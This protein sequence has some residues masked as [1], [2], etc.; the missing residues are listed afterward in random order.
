MNLEIQKIPVPK[1]YIH[2]DPPS[3]ILPKHEFTIGIIAPKGAGKTT[4]IINMLKFYKNYFNT[5][6]IFSPTVKSDEKWDH[7]KKQKLTVPNTPL[8]AILK[9][10][11]EKNK[12]I[13]GL[14]ERSVGNASEL[15]DIVDKIESHTPEIAEEHFFDDYDDDVFMAIMKEQKAMV[16]FLHEHD[17]PKYLADRLLV[18]FDDLVGS[19]LFKSKFFRG[20]N[21]RHRHYSASV[22]MVS[23]GYKEI[24]KTIRTQWSCL[25]T[26]EIGNEKEIFVIYEEYS[27]GL[28][29][30]EWLEVYRH[31]TDAEHDFMF[32]NFQK[33]KKERIMRN[34]QEIVGYNRDPAIEVVKRKYKYDAESNFEKRQKLETDEEPRKSKRQKTT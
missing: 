7:L 27:M 13:K 4:M 5:I 17:Y 15:Q 28:G 31:C 21:T 11:I 34:F 2:P 14:V 29:F 16:E 12:K 26:F 9:K 23:Q 10:M 24:Q 33:P 18:I 30:K 25:I 3:P 19:D 6:L 22:M 1:G 8:K 20:F 32:I